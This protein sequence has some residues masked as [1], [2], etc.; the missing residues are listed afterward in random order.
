MAAEGRQRRTELAAAVAAWQRPQLRAA[1]SA[2]AAFAGRR[3][4][5]RELVG[6]AVM[7][8]RAGQLSD[9]LRRWRNVASDKAW[10]REVEEH[11]AARRWR[12]L[13]STAFAGF[14]IQAARFAILRRTVL[15]LRQRAL[16]EAFAGWR[17]AAGEQRRLVAATCGALAR[18]RIRAA[19]AAFGAWRDAARWQRHS[20]GA[21]L[22]CVSRLRDRV[23]C[24]SR[25]NLYRVCREQ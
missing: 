9:A 22:L 23:R 4:E 24:R 16:A 3:A 19:A 15:R 8:W 10:Q 21:L 18:W 13:L 1:L 25:F 5:T 11:Y 12:W 6:A 14:R 20:R 17:G 7:R 2:W